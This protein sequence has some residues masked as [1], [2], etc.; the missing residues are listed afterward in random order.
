MP[1]FIIPYGSAKDEQRFKGLS[2]LVQGYIEAMFFTD[3]GSG[4]DKG[5]EHATFADLDDQTLAAIKLDC[6]KFYAM[7]EPLI[8]DAIS[9]SPKPYTLRR[10]GNDFW[11]TRNGH[12]TGFWDRDLPGELGEKLST[13]A[14]NFCGQTPYRGDD[15]KMYLM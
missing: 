3:T 5:L 4:D 8:S 10:A 12:G 9:L 7:A 6:D 11:Y 15:G 2:Y 14:K 13:I 1:E